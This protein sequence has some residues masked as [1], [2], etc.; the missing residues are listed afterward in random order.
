MKRGHAGVG[1]RGVAAGYLLLAVVA[2]GGNDKSSVTPDPANGGLAGAAG[3]AA[4]SGGGGAS[5]GTASANGGETAGANGGANGGVTTGGGAGA[6]PVA[7]STTFDATES[8]ISEGGHFHHLGLDWTTVNTDNGVA[9][10]TQALGVA[11][12]GPTGYDDSYAYLDGFSADQQA[13]AVV[14][15]G[16]IDTSCTHE[17]EVLLRWADSAHSAQGYECNVAFD[18]SYAQIV[19]WNGAVGDYTYLGSGSVPGGMHD[20]D[21]VSASVVGGHVTLSVNGTV[22]A[23]ADDATYPGGNPGIG[24]WRGDSG[25][26]TLGDYGFTSFQATSLGP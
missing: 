23:T 6:A 16:A 14:A 24:F 18:G 7:Y 4:A 12:S 10:G 22:R 1:S 15:L 9:F 5:G 8:P 25:C 11:R 17:V 3:H 26:G 19:R 21:T 13:S 2:C 20:G